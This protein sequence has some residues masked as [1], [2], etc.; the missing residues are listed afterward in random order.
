MADACHKINL[1][2][3][4]GRKWPLQIS[5]QPA[6]SPPFCTADGPEKRGIGRK[7]DQKTGDLES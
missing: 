1:M 4:Y 3:L 5:Q 7:W 6:I 2:L